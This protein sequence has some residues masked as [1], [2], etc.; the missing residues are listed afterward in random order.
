MKKASLLLLPVFALL[1]TAAAHSWADVRIPGPFIYGYM[2]KSGREAIPC[3]Y[4]RAMPFSEGLAAVSM[5][6][7]TVSSSIEKGGNSEQGSRKKSGEGTW[8]YIDKTGTQV[9]P[10]QFRSAGPF[11]DGLALVQRPGEREWNY[12]DPNGKVVLTVSHRYAHDFSEGLAVVVGERMRNGYI[13]KSGKMVIE[14]RF[15]MAKP[16]HDGLA[17]VE[18]DRKWGFIDKSGAVAI[19]FQFDEASSF[20]DGRAAVRLGNTCGYIDQSGGFVIPPQ[21]RQARSFSEGLA[22]VKLSPEKT[23]QLGRFKEWA[24]IDRWGNVVI[25]PQFVDAEPFSEG[26]AIV[27]RMHGTSGRCEV[28]DRSGKMVWGTRPVIG[29]YSDGL[30]PASGPLLRRAK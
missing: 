17:A 22:P 7:E 15:S 27:K 6:Q 18:V 12:I 24:Y 4:L 14:P 2:D 19:P 10:A 9:I 26:L 28:I 8:G 30:A 16:F 3:G 25:P 13:N 23:K 21:F 1:V 5:L 20:S 29:K 11:S